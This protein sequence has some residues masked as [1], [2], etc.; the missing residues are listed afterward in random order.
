MLGQASVGRTGSGLLLI[1]AAGL[2]Y[3]ASRLAVFA[4]ARGDGSNPGRR[5]LGQWLPV[6]ACALAAIFMGRADVA[7]SVI[8]GTSVAFLSLV[9]GLATYLAPMESLPAS[10]KSWPFILPAALLALLAGFSGHLA[11]WHALMLLA[12]GGAVLAVWL[13]SPEMSDP[14]APRS[15][16]G[17]IAVLAP[18]AVALAGYGA[19]QAVRGTLAS[20]GNS[21]LLSP[22]SVAAT[23]LSPL[24]V[25]PTL[26]NASALSQRGHTGRAVSALVGSVL[27]NLC[28]LLP[29]CVLLWY[30]HEAHWKLGFST[31]ADFRAPWE[32][33]HALPYP[34]AAWRVQTVILLVLGLALVPVSMGRWLF[35]RFES[36]ALVL[37]Y[38]AFLITLAVYG[39]ELV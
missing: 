9:L 1:I 17:L 28:L 21:H 23:I 22:G 15:P 13:E 38:A 29:A 10:R 11:W 26:G 25:L 37:G 16:A 20:S 2:L 19:Y 18:L 24:L 3:V 7:V 36:A 35:G 5:A 31:F 33:A 4:L 8:F 34:M 14:H 39:M 12:L 27:L 30:L 32:S 6:A